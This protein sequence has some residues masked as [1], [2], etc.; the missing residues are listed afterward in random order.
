MI[1]LLLLLSYTSIASTSLLLMRSLT[2]HEINKVY[3][4]ISPDIEYFHGRH[5]AYSIVALICAVFIVIGLPLL[6]TLEPFLNHKITFT[7]IKPL[8]DQFQG[9]YKDKYRCFAGYYM[10]CRLLIIVILI[11]NSSNDFTTNYMLI[12][13]CGII[14]LIHLI[15][16]PYANNGILNKFDGIILQLIIFT[17]ALPMFDNLNSPLVI[18]IAFVLITFPLLNFIAITLFFNRDDLKKI[19]KYFINKIESPNDYVRVTNDS[20]ANNE[21]E[22]REFKTIIVD[23]SKRKNAIICDV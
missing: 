12:I 3:T 21:T 22:L 2:F 17:A 13:A 18:T 23:D 10:T 14:A 8:L 19:I 6:L 7:K 4:Y 1:C 15:I 20:I 11:A 9:G 5:L 16:K